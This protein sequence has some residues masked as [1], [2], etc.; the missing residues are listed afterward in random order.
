MQAL[1]TY[2]PVLREW[3]Q[4]F[5]EDAAAALARQISR[6]KPENVVFRPKVFDPALSQD[7]RQSA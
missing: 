3:E 1:G 5:G 2:K 4:S 7:E 6:E